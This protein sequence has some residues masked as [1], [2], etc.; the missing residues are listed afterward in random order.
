MSFRAAEILSAGDLCREL[1]RSVDQ[2]RKTLRTNPDLLPEMLQREK[3]ELLFR[4]LTIEALFRI[5]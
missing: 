4:P 1:V 2:N 5:C 3:R